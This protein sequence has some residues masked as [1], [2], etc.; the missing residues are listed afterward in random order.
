[1]KYTEV[2]SHHW[3]GIPALQSSKNNRKISSMSIL[4]WLLSIAQGVTLTIKIVPTK[5]TNIQKPI[6]S[7]HV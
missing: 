2:H 5:Q 4:D 6:K 3:P 7:L 1:M